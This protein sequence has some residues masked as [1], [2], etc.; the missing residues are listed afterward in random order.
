MRST[1]KRLTGIILLC[2]SYAATAQTG[3]S[4]SAFRW[5]G[6]KLTGR[7][8]YQTASIKINN[9]D[10]SYEDLLKIPDSSLLKVEIYPKK[11]AQKLMGK[12][13]GQNG[14]VLVTLR[15]G[16][17]FD[18]ENKKRTPHYYVEGNDTLYCADIHAPTLNGD[19]TDVSW[20][21]FLQQNLKA[22]APADNG[23]PIGLYN[24]DMSF[25]VSKE[26]E[27]ND[28]SVLQDP[29]YGTGAEVRRLMRK[30]PLW[31]PGDCGGQPIDNLEYQRI[32]F[33]LQDYK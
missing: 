12:D 1:A 26:G 31:Q 6:M 2:I 24:V 7:V 9:K 5:M 18:G 27:V 30:A 22:G 14:L 25:H 15:R 8:S 29:G 21:K 4:Y 3:D 10:A 23:A 19:T 33:T 20:V 13:E 28:I 16:L 11:D 17:T 32:T